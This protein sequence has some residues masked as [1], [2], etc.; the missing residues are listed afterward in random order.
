LVGSVPT[1]APL[2]GDHF[3]RSRAAASR[4]VVRMR[5]RLVLA[6]M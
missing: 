1:N 5:Y 2:V 6:T 4:T 3:A